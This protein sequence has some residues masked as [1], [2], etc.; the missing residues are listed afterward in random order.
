MGNAAL[1]S[2]SIPNSKLATEI[3]RIASNYILSLTEKH[4]QYKISIYSI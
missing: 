2:T 4:H 3:D 1:T